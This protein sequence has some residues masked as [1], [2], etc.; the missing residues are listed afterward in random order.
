MSRYYFSK[1]EEVDDLH[2][3]NVH[4]LKKHG[5]FSR[6][7]RAGVINWSRRGEKVG[8]ITIQSIIDEIEKDINFIYTQTNRETGEKSH[9]DYRVPLVT[10]PCYFGGKRYWFI[11]PGYINGMNCRRRVG[12]LYL[13]GKYFACRHCYNLT[14]N[15][16][17]QGGIFKVVG[18][19][20][21]EPYLD[22]LRQQIK[23]EVYAGKI[24]RKFKRYLKKEKVYLK[25]Q[26]IVMR[27]L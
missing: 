13:S 1:K 15:S 14:Y 8:S 23:R 20:I 19:I 18:V 9:F 3:V 26:A 11:C 2:Q 24:T 4:F 7:G 27:Y 10:T 25:Q 21:S 17:N 16:R 22:E 12:T 6:G 5:Y